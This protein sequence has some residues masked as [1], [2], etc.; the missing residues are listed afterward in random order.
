MTIEDLCKDYLAA[1]NEGSVEKVL[2][3]FAPDAVVESPLYGIKPA[4]SFY[5]ELFADTTNS[6]TT[7]LHVFNNT[8]DNS[9]LALHFQYQ[10]T[11]KSGKLV[12]FECVDVFEISPA[13]DKFTK[14]TIIYD[15]APIRDDFNETHYPQE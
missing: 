6:K 15:T 11:L 2:S 12:E 9:S 8:S 3:L 7:L 4:T 5:H 13:G 10:W 1:L 14:L